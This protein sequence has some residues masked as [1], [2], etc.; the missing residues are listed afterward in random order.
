[1]RT[2]PQ[3]FP[4]PEKEVMTVRAHTAGE[5]LASLKV[6]EMV[7][8]NVRALQDFCHQPHN[9]NL[10]TIANHPRPEFSQSQVPEAPAAASAEHVQS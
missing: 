3:V 7:T 8:P 2:P 5:S 4:L 6:P 1:M 10:I 9:G